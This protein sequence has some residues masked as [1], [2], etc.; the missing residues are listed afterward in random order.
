[1]FGILI[2]P[3]TASLHSVYGLATALTKD[4][5]PNLEYG[6]PGRGQQPEFFFFFLPQHR[7]G[8]PPEDRS[9]S[10]PGIHRA[11]QSHV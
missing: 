10:Y 4:D 11:A 6:P 1:M 9:R 3:W 5:C 8:A 2:L 7:N